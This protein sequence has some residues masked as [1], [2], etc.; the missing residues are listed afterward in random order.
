ME[1]HI[2]ELIRENANLKE[3][4][5]KLEDSRENESKVF[6][7]KTQ[8]VEASLAE[9][10][11]AVQQEVTNKVHQQVQE[12]K[13]NI[14]IKVKRCM[15]IGFREQH[16]QQ[17][18]SL[19]VRIGGL[20]VEWDTNTPPFEELIMSLNEALSPNVSEDYVQ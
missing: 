10:V 13:K 19:R 1:E 9:T 8:E 7:T 18:N 14:N 5:R 2:Q 17:R 12:I 4:L 15:D 20:L 16:L 11:K 3:R 6:E